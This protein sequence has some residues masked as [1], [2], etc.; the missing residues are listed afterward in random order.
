MTYGNWLESEFDFTNYLLDLRHYHSFSRHTVL[1]GQVYLNVKNGE[2]P[3]KQAATLGGSSLLR[4]YYNGRYRDNNAL[5]I[6]AEVRQQLIG[7]LGGVLFAGLGDV[8]HSIRDFD[9][10]DLKP[11]GGGGLRFLISRREHLN[12]R[13]DAA[14]GKQ[15]HGF[16]V[17][18]SEAF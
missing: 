16:Y 11:T 12:I 7:R 13:F 4:G 15:T 14:V 17:N 5:I 9:I 18:I 2:V 3:F 8:A 6:Q 1:A 10:G